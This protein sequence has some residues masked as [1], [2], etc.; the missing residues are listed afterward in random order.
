MVRIQAA[1][2]LL[3]IGDEHG[4]ALIES[5]SSSP[6]YQDWFRARAVLASRAE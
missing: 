6:Q 5:L 2:A 3:V 4:L 1:N